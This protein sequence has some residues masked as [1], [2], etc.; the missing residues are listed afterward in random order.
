M[1]EIKEKPELP[2]D[3]STIENVDMALYNWLNETLDLYADTNSGWKKV[4]VIWVSGERSWQVK[5]NRDLRDSNN[6]FILPSITLERTSIAKDPNKKGKYWGNV[7]PSRDEKGGSIAIHQVINQEKTSNFAKADNKR[8]T[9]QPNFKRENKKVVYKTKFI[10][11][12]VYVTMTY[13]IDIT[14]EYQQQM[15]ELIQPFVTYSGALNYFM[16]K[17]NNHKYEAFLETNY[18]LK[19][20]SS[21]LQQ[22]ERSYNT[23][24]TI[25]VLA[26]LVGA[27]SNDKRPR[28]IE[29]ENAV[30]VKIPKEYTI[31]EQQ[32]ITAPFP[33]EDGV[34]DD[35]PIF[36]RTSDG[37][38]ILIS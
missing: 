2:Y 3:P 6:V 17:N 18:Q 37:D 16:I 23:K 8:L 7:Y 32:N 21:D 14:T 19:N 4:P 20:N 24:I 25:N 28:V 31:V 22:S 15:N 5:N 1:S 26:H 35:E 34:T 29:R 12:P 11:M 9:G 27:T 38:Y 36:I 13:V 33:L 30:E 10:P